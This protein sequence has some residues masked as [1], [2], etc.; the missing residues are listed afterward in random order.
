MINYKE[1]KKIVLCL[2]L[3]LTIFLFCGCATTDVLLV[4][5]SDGSLDLFY[6]F[7]LQTEKLIE[8]G[9]ISESDVKKMKS[10]LE[11]E[12][13]RYIE[14]AKN[15]FRFS[16]AK[17]ASQGVISQSE[18]EKVY[19]NLIFA[20]GWSENTFLIKLSFADTK[21]YLIYTNYGEDITVSKK[22]DEQ[23]FVT[24]Y[25]ESYLNLFGREKAEFDNKCAYDFFSDKVSDYLNKHFSNKVL[26]NFPE[27]TMTYSYVTNSSRLHSNADSIS[28]TTSG[29]LHSWK[30]DSESKDKIIEF[31]TLEANRVVWYIIA[32]TAGLTFSAV[33]LIVVF[34]KK[35]KCSLEETKPDV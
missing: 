5:N 29:T 35:S 30:I 8:N 27:L 2:I 4:E 3:C 15:Q 7:T 33:L 23:F 20:T 28:H 1:M 31:Y 26:K 18:R 13:I 34:F 6:A 10:E 14:K 32:L 21:T 12:S 11:T 22:T 24:I 17:Y 25:S 9:D 16:I 19:S